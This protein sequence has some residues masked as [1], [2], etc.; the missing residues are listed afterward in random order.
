MVEIIKPSYTE[1]HR[2]MTTPK[3]FA[4]PTPKLGY[5]INEVEKIFIEKQNEHDLHTFHNSRPISKTSIY[6]KILENYFK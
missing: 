4:S 6:Y 1:K 3:V 5:K 2:N